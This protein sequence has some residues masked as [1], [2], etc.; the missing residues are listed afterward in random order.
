MDATEKEGPT[1][2]HRRRRITRIWLADER[3]DWES[4]DSHDLESR[5]WLMETAHHAV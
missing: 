2:G 5:G 3:L 4:L 1:H